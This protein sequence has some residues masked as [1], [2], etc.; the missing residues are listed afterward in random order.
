FA[1]TSSHQKARTTTDKN[2]LRGLSECDTQIFLETLNR[3]LDNRYFT[4][5]E[6]RPRTNNRNGLSSTQLKQRLRLLIENKCLSKAVDLIKRA[7]DPSPTITIDRPLMDKLQEL[8]PTKRPMDDIPLG[9]RTNNHL[10]LSTED[11]GLGVHNLPRH[12]A[13]G[14]SGWSYDLLRSLGS[15]SSSSEF[16][17]LLKDLFN[18]FLAGRGGDPSAWT[19]SR[20]FPLPKPDG[21]VRPIAVGEVWIRLLS[22]IVLKRIGD[23]IVKD[24]LPFQWAIAVKGGAEILCHTLHLLK[25]II[26]NCDEP[27]LENI[28]NLMPK[29]SCIQS[30]DLHNAFNCI[31]RS[32]IHKAIES[33]CPQILAFFRWSYGNQS[34]LRLS[35][36]NIIQSGAG[37]RQG[38]PL[39]S[40]Y[41]CLGIRESI[42]RLHQQFSDVHIFAYADNIHLLAH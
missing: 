11:V 3:E 17:V 9:I 32:S 39:G 35:N 40:L 28:S 8:H 2:I 7:N 36:G 24:L 37:V 30:I 6:S 15:G 42:N 29:S 26:L 31:S 14:L 13:G 18:L 1:L 10:S 12:R 21:G 27:A 19:A 34:S 5:L 4:W 20:L 16:I 25:H 33:C 38:D 41:F 22:R 23:D